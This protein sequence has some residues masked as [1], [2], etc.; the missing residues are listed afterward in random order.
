MTLPL[1]RVVTRTVT[2]YYSHADRAEGLD[3]LSIVRVTIDLDGGEP[4]VRP[5]DS[6]DDDMVDVDEL[7]RQG[8][9]QYVTARLHLRS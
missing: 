4:V 7:R 6:E 8:R 3:G 1:A 2:E 5:G 9:G